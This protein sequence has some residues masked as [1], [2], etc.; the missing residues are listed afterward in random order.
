MSGYRADLDAITAAASVLR[1]T[2]D[3]LASVRDRLDTTVCAG[4]G[5]ERLGAVAASLTEDAR[6]DLDRV[7][8]AVIED[9]E[10]VDLAARGYADAD[11][12]AAELL[13]RRAGEPG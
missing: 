4:I 9:A 5:P 3:S 2:V 1:S 11:R 8:R 13:A 12:A 6:A 10:L 7:R